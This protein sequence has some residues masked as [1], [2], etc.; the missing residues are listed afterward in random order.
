MGVVGNSSGAGQGLPDSVRS[1]IERELRHRRR[2]QE[3]EWTDAKLGAFSQ[4][5]ADILASIQARRLAAVFGS[6]PLPAY[7]LLVAN[8]AAITRGWPTIVWEVIKST[9]D[10][11]PTVSVDHQT[12]NSMVDEFAWAITQ[13]PFTLEYVDAERFKA[14]VVREAIRYGLAPQDGNFRALNLEGAAWHAGIISIGREARVATGIAIDRYLFTRLRL[15]HPPVLE[16]AMDGEAN[17]FYLTGEHWSVTY[18]GKS[19]TFTNT[20]GLRYIA[21][22]IQ[23][24]GKEILV[25]D[26]YYAINPPDSESADPIYSSMSEIRRGEEGLSLGDLGDAGEILT[27]EGKKRLEAEVRRIQDRIDDAVERGDEE[28]QAK[29]EAQQE[30]ILGHIAAGAGLGGKPRKAS[31]AIERIRK[32]VSKRI[33]NDIEKITPVFPDL[34]RHLDAA[35]RTG[36]HCQYSPHPPVEWSLDP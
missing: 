2:Q 22:L 19:R 4:L 5:R 3:Q 11:V 26:L 6:A 8:A 16:N 14:T 28:D 31:S 12:L 34:G 9:L 29:L 20:K 35:I 21:Y 32:A 18:K 1:L 17:R 24:Q 30:Q 7:K 23:N 25:S 36:T 15:T 27:P 13:H 10:Q 33:H